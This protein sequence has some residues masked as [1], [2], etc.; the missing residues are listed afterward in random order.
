M[1]IKEK[2]LFIFDLD[3]VVYLGREPVPGAKELLETLEESGKKVFYLTNNS[4]RTRA[5]FK[6]KLSKMGI[7]AQESQIITSAFSTAQYLQQIAPGSTV[8]IIGEEGLIREFEE[9]G[10]QV[11]LD[12]DLKRKI[13]Y[14]VV[15]LDRSFTFQKL[16]IGLRAIDKGAKFIA[17]NTDPT[18][19]TEKGN[20]PGA[21]SMIAALR[22]A[23]STDPSIIIGKPNPFMIDLILKKQNMHPDSAVIIGDRYSTDVLAG[24][25]AKIGTILVKTGTGLQEMKLIPPEGPRPDLILESIVEI[26]KYL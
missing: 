9:A 16:A 3:G 19:P 5:K 20:L 24:I 7:T 10:F 4:T 21:G 12:G 18:L 17:T 23:A 15:G 26:R 22:T 6:E 11:N 25:N 2:Q 8:F 13:N 14:V 1:N